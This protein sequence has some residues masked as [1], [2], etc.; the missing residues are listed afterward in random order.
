MATLFTKIIQGELPS[1]KV[2]EDDKYFAFLSIEPLTEGHTLLIPK[3]ESVTWTD[4]TADE[5]KEIFSVALTLGQKLKAI[6]KVPRVA[7]IIA[8][9]QVEHTHLHLIPCHSEGELDFSLAKRA[10]HADL[11]RIHKRIIV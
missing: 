9:F 4:L 6:F 7:L 11:E 10:E 2:Y 1:Y 5:V 8:G 3:K